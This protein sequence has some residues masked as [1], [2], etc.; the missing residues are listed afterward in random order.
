MVTD[1]QLKE[2]ISADKQNQLGVPKYSVAEQVAI[3]DSRRL[4]GMI[5]F[6][7]DRKS[8]Q[9]YQG[10]TGSTYD[11]TELTNFLWADKTNIGI[12]SPQQK[13]V[14]EAFINTRGKMNT[15][16]IVTLQ[17]LQEVSVAG[18]IKSTLDW[19][20]TNIINTDTLASTGSPTLQ[21]IT[22]VLASDTI[23]DDEIVNV[24]IESLQVQI[25]H[26]EI[27]CI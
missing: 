17:Y 26:I 6:N 11:I 8:V 1:W 18:E 24:W 16:V 27:R 19:S 13:I 21:E 7:T 9:I 4:V 2:L 20:G 22:Y 3:L 10:G 23:T 25:Q 15:S 5:S 12:T 14:N